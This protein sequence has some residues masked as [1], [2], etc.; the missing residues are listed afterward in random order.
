MPTKNEA[1]YVASPARLGSLALPCPV[2]SKK[3]AQLPSLGT[4][5]L[6]PDPKDPTSTILELDELWLYD[7]PS[8]TPQAE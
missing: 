6:A 1:A 8:S 7:F 2:G 5:L 4:T 3:V